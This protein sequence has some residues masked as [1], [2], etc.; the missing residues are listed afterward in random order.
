MNNAEVFLLTKEGAWALLTG[1]FIF[2]ALILLIRGLLRGKNKP[3]LWAWVVRAAICV[4]A[5]GAQL[6]QGA[7][8]SLALTLSQALS[9]LCIIG[10][11]LYIKSDKNKLDKTDWAAMTIAG[12]GVVFWGTSGN[13][14]Y[15]IFCVMLADTCATVMS[16]RSGLKNG[17]RESVGF[18]ACALIAAS[19]A[20]LSAKN[21]A[22]PVFI[23][24]LFS[25]VNACTNILSALYIKRVSPQS[26]QI[27]LLSPL[28]EVE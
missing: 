19:M 4:V 6:S 16:I 7:T 22:W 3:S 21:A 15:G 12:L 26:K 23:A 5:F 25:C 28:A 27:T 18:W 17:S 20:A 11:L 24:P 1:F 8:Y 2:L 9:C 10:L 14:L 13:S